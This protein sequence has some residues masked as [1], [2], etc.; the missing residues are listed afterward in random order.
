MLIFAPT[1]KAQNNNKS[2]QQTISHRIDLLQSENIELLYQN[3]MKCNR[4]S[5][6]AHPTTHTHN[7]SAQKAADSDQMRIAVARACE[8]TSVAVINNH[9]IDIVHKLYVQ[10]TPHPG[11]TTQI[12]PIQPFHLPEDI[13]TTI[14]NAQKKIECFEKQSKLIVQQENE[15]K[16]KEELQKVEAE[17]ARIQVETEKLVAEKARIQAEAEKLEVEK[18]NVKKDTH[19]HRNNCYRFNYFLQL[20]QKGYKKIQSFCRYTNKGW[21]FSHYH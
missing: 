9:N 7:Q 16:I 11:H 3:S 4:H 17:K 14:K 20:V 21:R 2:I 12:E 1:T 10:P 15:R 8:T 13:C 5:Q 6:N 18:A 19:H